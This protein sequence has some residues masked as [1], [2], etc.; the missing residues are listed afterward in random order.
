M[1]PASQAF[2]TGTYTFLFVSQPGVPLAV[3][4]LCLT[5][6]ASTALTQR[7]GV[8]FSRGFYGKTKEDI[9]LENAGQYL[10]ETFGTAMRIIWAV[11]LLAAGAPSPHA[12]VPGMCLR[13]CSRGP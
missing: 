9:G 6:P 12:A 3:A 10:G 7:P 8:P 4:H 13:G 2:L 1:N 5:N 11:G